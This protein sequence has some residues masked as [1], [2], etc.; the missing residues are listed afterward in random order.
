MSSQTRRYLIFGAYGGIGSTLCRSLAQ[1]GAKLVVSGRDRAELETLAREIDAPSVVADAADF[2]DVA[3]ATD[4]AAEE[5]GGLDGVVSCVGSVLLKPAHLTS[6]DDWADTV[7]TNLTSSFAIVRSATKAL[8]G[9]GGGSVV[10]VSTAAASIGLPNHEAIAA[11][12]GGVDALVRSAAATYGSAGIRVNAVSPGLVETPL[13]R[14]ITG[15]E[16][17]LE[18]SRAMHALGRI[19]APEDVASAIRWLLSDAASWITGEVVGVD[20]GLGR[21]R[22]A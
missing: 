20:G 14:R 12:K 17:A 13:T 8:R 2:Q 18:S 19:G 9:S 21:V 15:N 6:E 10:L 16:K 1:E 22:S 7:R 3:R 4:E 5:L 11:A